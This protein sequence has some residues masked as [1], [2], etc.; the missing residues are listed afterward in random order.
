MF[1]LLILKKKRN[2]IWYTYILDDGGE[3]YY[4]LLFLNIMNWYKNTDISLYFKIN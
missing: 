4:S 1:Y 3:V 2:I